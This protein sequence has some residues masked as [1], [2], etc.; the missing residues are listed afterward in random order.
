MTSGVVIG[1]GAWKV[2]SES[3]YMDKFHVDTH[4]WLSKNWKRNACIQITHDASL[5]SLDV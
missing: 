4:V 3:S 5:A 2:I 1:N